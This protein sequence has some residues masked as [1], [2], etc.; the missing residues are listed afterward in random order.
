MLYIV[1]FGPPGSGKGTQSEKIIEKYGLT[2]ISTGDMLRYE[3]NQGTEL[4]INAKNYINQGQL[5]PDEIIIGM[6][7]NK[8]LE[9]EHQSQGI[10]F[11][12]FPRTVTQ[13][14]ALK[15][16][17]TLRGE[18]I[19]IMLDLVV[20]KQE[21]ITRLIKRGETS[22]RADDTPETIEKRLT[23]YDNVTSPVINFFK[24]EGCYCS[25]TQTG[26][27]D[28]IF[29]AVEAALDPVLLK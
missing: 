14:E 22:G 16:L 3:M 28:E 27:I 8:I 19:S 5:V 10:I 1:I 6:I 13:A 2:H 29:G 23:V 26:T 20:E 11:D 17:L 4:G 24:K 7:K 18:R 12:G 15:Q 9:V 25:I 21:L